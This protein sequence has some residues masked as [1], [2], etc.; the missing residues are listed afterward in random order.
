MQ[1]YAYCADIAVGELEE[2][3]HFD[4]YPSSDAA[5]FNWTWSNCRTSLRAS[6]CHMEEGL[7][8]LRL[9]GELNDAGCTDVA[10]CN[11][12]PSALVDDGSCLEF[13]V[14]GGCGEALLRGLHGRGRVQLRGGCDHRRRSCFEVDAPLPNRPCKPPSP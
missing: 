10:A 4:L 9:S 7:F 3:G 8:L 12:D 6:S 2:V 1:V 5:Q 14:C 11:Y 13:N